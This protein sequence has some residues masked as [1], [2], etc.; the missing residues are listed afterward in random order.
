MKRI[1]HLLVGL[2]IAVTFFL[3]CTPTQQVSNNTN[4]VTNVSNIRIGYIPI[5]DCLPLYVAQEKGFFAKQALTVQITPLQGGPR[6]I[7]ALSGNSIDVG[8]VNVVSVITAHSKGLPIVSIAGGPI[9]TENKKAHALLVSESSTIKQPQ[10]LSGKTIAVNALRNI[11]HVILRQYL[12]KNGVDVNSV[13]IV[14]SPFPQMEGLLKGGTA[15]AVMLV[16]PFISL[17]LSHKTARILGHPY[18]D[19]RNRNI[20]ANYNVKSDWLAQ[21]GETAKKFATALNEANTF[22]A[23]N[24]AESRQILAKY[25]QIPPEILDK[26]VIPEF[27]NQFSQED[28]QFWIGELSRQGIIEKQ[29]SAVDILKQN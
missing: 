15:D 26:V 2:L 13:K 23:Q 8:Y 6:V 16:E 3:G 12:E 24:D 10:D 17:A 4:T 18:T 28:L 7:E 11:E 14:E 29:V 20:V 5:V 1:R 19:V 9:E 21:N 25:T 27:L 22:I